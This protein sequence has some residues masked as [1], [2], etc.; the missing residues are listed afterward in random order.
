ME[1]K[2]I[3]R[4][5][6]LID[7]NGGLYTLDEVIRNMR[8]DQSR[9]RE[10]I[11]QHELIALTFDERNLVFPRFQFNDI[12]TQLVV[13]MAEFLAYHQGWN[14]LELCEFLLTRM[15]PEWSPR[16]PLDALK[17]GRLYKV[18]ELADNH[19]MQVG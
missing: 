6:N 13:G 11:L 4:L 12:G 10:K 7:D 2:S 1:L 9:I 15:D 8:V 17:E 18:C 14:R 16:T 5:K 3:E 19:K